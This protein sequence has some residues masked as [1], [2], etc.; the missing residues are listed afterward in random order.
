MCNLR[1][2]LVAHKLISGTGEDRPCIVICTHVHFDHSGGANAFPD[3]RIHELDKPG[4]ALGRQTETLNYVKPDHFFQQPYPGFNARSY[5]VPPTVC[6]GL[7]DRDE[8]SLGGHEYLQILHVPGHTKGS[9]CVHYPAKNALFSGDFAY[10]C[11]HGG[12]LFDWL[13]NSNKRDFVQ[14]AGQMLE[15][16][17]DHDIVTVYPGHFQV[18]PAARMM[19]LLGEYLEA[20]DNCSSTVQASCLQRVTWCYFLTNCFRCCPC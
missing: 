9:I 7:T 13:P 18:L 10:E 1:D 19:D 2:Y 8:I 5:K 16:A 14:S 6:T 4:L 20:R 3:V 11:G 12:N 15:F 17:T